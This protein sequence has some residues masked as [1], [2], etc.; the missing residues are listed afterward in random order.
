MNEGRRE[1]VVDDGGDALVVGVRPV[2]IVGAFR[3]ALCRNPDS[4][5]M[6][7]TNRGLAAVSP[8]LFIV[9]EEIEAVG[10][11]RRTSAVSWSSKMSGTGLVP[12]ASD[13]GAAAGPPR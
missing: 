5:R 12:V 1:V 4:V 7:P 6:S 2:G 10:W 8:A 13:G 3:R 11:A 9:A